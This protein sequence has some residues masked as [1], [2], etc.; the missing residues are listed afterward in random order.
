MLF[1]KQWR[2]EVLHAEIYQGDIAGI[3]NYRNYNLGSVGRLFR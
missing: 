3:D 2:L 1:L